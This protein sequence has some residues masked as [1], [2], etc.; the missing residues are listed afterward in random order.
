V[1]SHRE[2]EGFILIEI[3]VAMAVMAIV[4]FGTLIMGDVSARLQTEANLR[5]DAVNEILGQERDRIRTLPTNQVALSPSATIEND[6]RGSAATNL[7]T[8]PTGTIVHAEE[9]DSRFRI[10]RYVYT[11]SD[12]CGAP[13][14]NCPIIVRL[15]VERTAGQK[16]RPDGI[17]A[18]EFAYL[19][20]RSDYGE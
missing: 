6:Y 11:P 14:P 12:G 8:L 5:M 3:I 18:Q 13:A 15:V 7:R 4:I 10:Y 20:P 2:E 16:N 1:N 19:A 9:L 17:V